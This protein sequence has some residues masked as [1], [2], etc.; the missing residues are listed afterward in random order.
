MSMSGSTRP[1]AYRRVGAAPIELGNSELGNNEL[2][3]RLLGARLL[4]A[5]LLDVGVIVEVLV[6][7]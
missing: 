2:G 5:R 4:G 7:V 6:A 3:K 1:S